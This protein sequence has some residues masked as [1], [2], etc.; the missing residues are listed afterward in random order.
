MLRKLCYK[1]R[2]MQQLSV[3]HLQNSR[4]VMFLASGTYFTAWCFLV[5]MTQVSVLRST[6]ANTCSKWQRGI[7][8]T[9]QEEVL[10]E[11]PQLTVNSNQLRIQEIK[12]TVTLTTQEL[13]REE[14]HR[15]SRWSTSFKKWTDMPEHLAWSLQT[16]LILM[17]YHT[18]IISPL[19]LILVSFRV[20][21]CRT[22]S[23]V[24]LLTKASTSAKVKI[25]TTSQESI[26]GQTP[27]SSWAKDSTVLK[28]VSHQLLDHVCRHRSRKI[29]ST[30]LSSW[31]IQKPWTIVGLK[32]QS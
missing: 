19:L 7:R 2:R 5:G 30:L 10:V 17:D 3:A 9:R 26:S 32:C 13:T 20:S 8:I 1:S 29:V 28:Q 15:T 6:L 24:T 23:S 22:Q 14:F 21:P 25:S 11:L 27:I 16:L 12:Q 18:R 31:W 4:Q